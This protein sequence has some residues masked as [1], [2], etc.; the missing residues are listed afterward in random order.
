MVTKC[1]ASVNVKGPK[2]SLHAP[3]QVSAPGVTINC[4]TLSEV[5]VPELEGLAMIS[6]SVGAEPLL[7]KTS[8][9]AVLSASKSMANWAF[10]PR[11]KTARNKKV[12]SF[13]MS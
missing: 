4:S 13:F 3:T 6:K 1:E 7:P 10:T 9:V 8:Q 11:V 2:L 12:K 5:L